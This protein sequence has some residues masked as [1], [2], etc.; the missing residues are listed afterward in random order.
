MPYLAVLLC[1]VCDHLL[2]YRFLSQGGR[3][4]NP[5]MDIV[6]AQPFW[7]SF[8]VKNGWTALLLVGLFYLGRQSRRGAKIGLAVLLSA[9]G[10]VMAY[11]VYGFM[12]CY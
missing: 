6:M 10:L 3:E 8:V 11:H 1:S 9:Y 2:T 12:W 7:V 5:V 4:L